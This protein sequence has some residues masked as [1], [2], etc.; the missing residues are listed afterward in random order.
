MALTTAQLQALK[1]EIL[2]DPVLTAQPQ[3]SDGAF[4]IAAALNLLAA[5][6]FIVWKTNVSTADVRAALV[7]SEYDALSVSKQNAFSFLCSN[8]IVNAAL[9]NVRQGISSIFSGP[10]QSGNLA[11]LIA[12]AKRRATRAEKVLATGTGTDASPATMGFEGT[13]SYQDVE[14][15]R[16]S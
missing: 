5:P 8:G 14:A 12:I 13:L 2:N 16:A 9:T 1:T 11:A 15:A 4:A 10:S 6:A 7:W 3:N